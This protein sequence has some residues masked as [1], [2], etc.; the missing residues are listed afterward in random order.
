MAD[1]K[2]S[3]LPKF[4]FLETVT[5]LAGTPNRPHISTN[6]H[7]TSRYTFLRLLPLNI[8]CMC[9]RYV[10]LSGKYVDPSFFRFT[11]E[12]ANAILFLTGPESSYVTGATLAAD[13]GR[14]LH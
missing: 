5:H 10:L 12:I 4:S 7:S 14:T 11:V 3:A 2:E 1:A 13:G 6:Y 8:S 9:H